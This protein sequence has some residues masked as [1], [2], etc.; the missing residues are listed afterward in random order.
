MGP[1]GR[2]T[3]HR[4]L[5]SGALALAVGLVLGCVP[6]AG[7]P[8]AP[9]S[10]P[11]EQAVATASTDSTERPALQAARQ[12]LAGPV[13]GLAETTLDVA[14]RVDF[15]R[16]D[17]DRGPAMRQ[18]V[19]DAAALMETLEEDATSLESAVAGMGGVL[20]PTRDAVEGLVDYSRSVLADVRRETD[21]LQPLLDLDDRMSAVIQRWDDRG[22]R[23]EAAEQLNALV[24]EAQ[25]VH[26]QAAL[27]RVPP[28]NCPGLQTNRVR[29]ADLVL[30]RTADLR[31]AA[32]AADGPT[33]DRLLR[34][35]RTAPY[36]EDRVAAD[37]GSRGCWA[38]N[39]D[40]PLV[41]SAIEEHLTAIEDALGL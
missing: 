26:E 28:S 13:T 16:H 38:A 34:G 33:Y 11:E 3:A 12:D 8:V 17:V 41:E 18:A 35:F 32:V 30:Q 39:S 5:R 4:R 37:G 6:D 24:V 29:W 9:P 1:S 19:A 15:I 23:S 36:G 31:D 40:L 20:R 21:A 10:P 14:R 2:G 27:L 22:S 25:A 7:D